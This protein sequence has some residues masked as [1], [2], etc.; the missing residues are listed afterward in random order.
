MSAQLHFIQDR[1]EI[2]QVFLKTHLFHLPFRR[3]HLGA[4]SSDRHHGLSTATKA[5]RG[6]CIV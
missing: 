4:L 2:F 1:A 5:T 6:T 3:E